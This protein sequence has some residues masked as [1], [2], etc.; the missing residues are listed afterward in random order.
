[1]M[2]NINLNIMGHVLIKDFETG[3]IILNKKNDI[4][5]ENMSEALTSVLSNTLS[6]SNNIGIINKVIFGN[7][8]IIVNDEGNINY[9]YPRV[10]NLIDN[11]YNQTLSV[12]VDYDESTDEDNNVISSHIDGTNYSDV[13]VTCSLDYGDPT[14]QENTVDSTDITSQYVF[15]ELGLLSNKGRLLSHLIFHP[16]QKSANR[17]FQIIYT[18]RFSITG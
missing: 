2:E 6:S 18:L 8:G 5:K 7:G 16:I 14:D 9:K 17:K 1:M 3:D 12:D 11:L 4:H 13:V 15:N 10:N